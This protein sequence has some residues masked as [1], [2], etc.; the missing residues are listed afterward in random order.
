MSEND[1]RDY[2]TY[3]SKLIF[4]DNEE[5][6][7]NQNDIVVF[8][9]PN[10]AGKS[11]SLKDIYELCD[12]KKPSTVISD[13]EIYKP[14]DSLIDYVTSISNVQDHGNYKTYQG[15]N[16][17][18]N[19]VNDRDNHFGNAQNIFVSYLNTET[20]LS[21]CKPPQNINRNAPKTHPIH[22][23]AF[24]Q[25][26][27]MKISDYFN[28]AFAT[29]IIPNTQYGATIPLCMG[30][31]ISVNKE[32]ES[33]F[34]VQMENYADILE[35][36][37]Q[38]HNQGDG[39]RSFTGILLNLIIEHHKIFL[40]D[41]PES[42]LHPPQA[43]IMGHTIGSLLSD[44]QQAFISTHS[45]EILKGLLETCPN[46]IKIVRITRNDNTNN[47]SILNNDEFNLLWKDPLLRHS[48]I[49]SSI[50]H[51]NVVLCESDSD[52]RLYSIIDSYIKETKTLFLK[53]YL[54]IVVENIEWAKLFLHLSH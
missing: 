37:P 38:I 48:E 49:M 8:V 26:Y 14:T 3:I 20:R 53:H 46:R 1:K 24:N 25:H 52:C 39:I 32:N 47:F 36:Y 5:L 15:L 19:S 18:F 13:I 51:K 45:P 16:Y 11:Q 29:N 28:K 12:S 22:N 10:N 44:K 54:F 4:N 23:V 50:F 31:S 2:N 35:Q 42:F 33:D 34:L 7:V 41:E 21:I 43:R 9:G 40:I 27:R 17:S 6:N 30:E